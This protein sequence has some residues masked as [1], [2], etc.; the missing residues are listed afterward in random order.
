MCPYYIQDNW[1]KN[2]HLDYSLAWR[3]FKE[4]QRET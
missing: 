4:N 2:V 1:F 3:V